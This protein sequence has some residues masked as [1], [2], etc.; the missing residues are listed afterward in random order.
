MCVL[1]G[2]TTPLSAKTFLGK[3]V[4]GIVQPGG[5]GFAVPLSAL[6][7]L[8]CGNQR[9]FFAAKCWISALPPWP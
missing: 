5:S 8:L 6:T 2:D 1:P 4:G 7:R 9:L 3:V